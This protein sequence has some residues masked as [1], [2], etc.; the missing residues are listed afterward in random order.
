MLVAQQ[1]LILIAS[2]AF[3][4]LAA[5]LSG[6]CALFQP[7]VGDLKF[8]SVE[9]RGRAPNFATSVTHTLSLRF[10]TER[11]LFELASGN[12]PYLDV[13]VCP[14]T[15]PSLPN[16][17]I[18]VPGRASWSEYW[19]SRPAPDLAGDGPHEYEVLIGYDVGFLTEG[20]MRESGITTPP[21]LCFEVHAP[22]YFGMG[23]FKSKIAVIPKEALS[24]AL[25]TAPDAR[26]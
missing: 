13:G 16:S 25:A 17:S 23:G 19:W 12:G 6:A 26:R 10:T 21:D 22:A 15:R 20:K 5:L 3:V 14:A 18:S 8:M 1:R 9:R 4:A 7:Y 11:N 2:P 24:A